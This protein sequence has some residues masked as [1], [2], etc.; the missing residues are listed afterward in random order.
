MDDAKRDGLT[1]VK[2]RKASKLDAAKVLEI[3]ALK[4]K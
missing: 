4:R 3:V 2:G 1:A